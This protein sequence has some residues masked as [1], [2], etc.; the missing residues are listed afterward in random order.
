MRTYWILGLLAL[1]SLAVGSDA[2]AQRLVS[3]KW[4]IVSQA[5][6]D[7]QSLNMG[8]QRIVKKQIE[9]CFEKNTVEGAR[10]AFI[11]Y[12]LDPK[13]VN[14]TV[15]QL[16]QR[17]EDAT[18]PDLQA[19]IARALGDIGPK[20]QE[21]VPTLR[22]AYDKQSNPYSTL[23]QNLVYALGRF[24]TPETKR[25]AEQYHERYDPSAPDEQ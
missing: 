4:K 16:I 22:A 13:T 10:A 23:T 7:F 25:I 11:L 19:E 18:S 15:S 2:L 20:A 21:A 24:D 5:L 8:E 17:F 3:S 14:R 1:S 6:R 9:Q 12:K